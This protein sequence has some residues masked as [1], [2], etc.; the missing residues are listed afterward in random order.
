MSDLAATVTVPDFSP[1]ERAQ[2]RQLLTS[3]THSSQF[4]PR[5]FAIWGHAAAA[6]VAIAGAVFVVGFTGAFIVGM[7]RAAAK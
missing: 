6:Y 2:I 5:A 7:I 4:W 1:E 3:K